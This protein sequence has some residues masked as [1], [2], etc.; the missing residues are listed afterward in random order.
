M[1]AVFAREADFLLE[2]HCQATTGIWLSAGPALRLPRGASPAE[3]GAAIRACLNES[4]RGVPHPQDWRKVVPPVLQLAG[5]RSW[6]ALQRSA[7][8]CR[9]EAGPELLR[10]VPHRNGGT[11]GNERGYHPLEDQAVTL[12][13]SATDEELGSAV[14]ASID[15][16]ARPW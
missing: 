15:L 1:M 12:A 11:R 9:V 5:V 2:P 3:L 6:A 14:L 10:V 16:S 4:R 8:M 7:A 13:P